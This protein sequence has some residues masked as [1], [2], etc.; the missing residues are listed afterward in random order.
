[1]KS[2]AARPSEYQAPRAIQPCGHKPAAVI[3]ARNFQ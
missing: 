1:M 3:L 2:P